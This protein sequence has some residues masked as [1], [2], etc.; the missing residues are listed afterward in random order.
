[1]T[2][3][4]DGTTASGGLQVNDSRASGDNP[5]LWEYLV[6][7]VKSEQAV[8]V[9]AKKV[10]DAETSQAKYL[11]NIQ[12]LDLLGTNANYVPKGWTCKQGEGADDYHI[13]GNDYSVG[14][15]RV[16]EG[17]SGYQGKALYWRQGYAAYGFQ[18]GYQLILQ[19]GEYVLTY[20]MAAWK[21]SPNYKVEVLEYNNLNI[22]KESD[23]IAATPDAGGKSSAD[24]SGAERNQ[25]SFTIGSTGR[26]II[27][28]SQKGDGFLEFLLLEC[29]LTSEKK[30]FEYTA[31]A[32]GDD[33]FAMSLPKNA[34]ES[35]VRL[36]FQGYEV[37]KIAV[38]TDPKTLNVK[39][40]TSESRARVID[41]SLTSY[42]SGKKFRTYIVSDVNYDNRVV[43]LT[44]IDN[45]GE[46]C[47]MPAAAA[48]G[49][50]NAC[51]IL[52]GTADSGI[53]GSS[54]GVFGDQF[55]LFVPDMHDYGT[56]DDDDE[57]EV[58]YSKSL[59][60]TS[61]SKLKAQLNEGYVYAVDGNYTNFAFTCMYYDIDPKTGAKKSEKKVGP[62]AFY[63][64]AGGKTGKASS[65]G[66]QGYLP[67]LTS[68]VGYPV[69]SSTS[70]GGGNA[71]FTLV[72]IDDDEA[73]GI[74]TVEQVAED[75][76]RFYNLSG[77]QLSGKPNRSGL[78]IVN[79]KKVYIKNK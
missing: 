22:V 45:V 76:G 25:L 31:T 11:M 18:D 32:N 26:Y 16:F 54:A 27:R 48:D 58:T 40:W 78:Y 46:G 15:S 52:N 19:P 14:G 43:T 8:Y 17:F 72:I 49:D 69:E 29:N 4:G 64:I 65:K 63:R 9:H 39:G 77:Q 3:T 24:L 36:C 57:E 47:L 44:R 74:A 34:T 75:N 56:E 41:P 23:Y 13:P 62:Q 68:K 73:T 37:N 66:N 55:H 5:L 60:D 53:E 61:G 7:S 38:S 12:S 71:R 28:F 70:T 33:I 1:M 59:Y 21:G 10:S 35:D 50:I 42:M 6:P 67:I 51:L 20:T 2:I 79:G 30:N